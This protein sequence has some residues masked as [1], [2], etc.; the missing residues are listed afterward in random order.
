LTT[1]WLN[2]CLQLIL[3]AL[4]HHDG[5]EFYSELGIE[6]SELK[7]NDPHVFLNAIQVKNILITAEDTRI[8]TRM[9]ELNNEVSNQEELNKRIRN[10]ENLRLNLISGQQC[11]RDFFICL[12]ENARC[13]PDVYTHFSFNVTH[14]STCLSC[15][16]V[17]R[18]QNSQPFIEVSVPP[19]N[20]H[21]N[22]SLELYFN[23]ASL[24]E[25]SCEFCKTT[26]QTEVKNEITCIADTKFITVVLS[27]CL[28]SLEG[29]QLNMNQVTSTEDMFIR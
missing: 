2:S 13:W 15:K 6:L 29:N 19:E 22:T 16:S 18:S 14:S 8:A 7:A 10:I 27:R 20:S 12:E 25:S 5:W 1:C 3:V 24:V 26:V 28:D 4:D 17:N 21:L 23:A 11:S 9:S